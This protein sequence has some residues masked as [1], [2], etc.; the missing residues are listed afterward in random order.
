MHAA[1]D[2]HLYVHGSRATMP[3][4]LAFLRQYLRPRPGGLVEEVGVC[5]RGDQAL[6]ATIVR[7]A[8]M[9]RPLPAWVVLHGLTY[10]GKEHPSLA[11]FTHAVAARASTIVE[12]KSL[13]TARVSHDFP[14]RATTSEIPSRSPVPGASRG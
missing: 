8:R 10:H 9:R 12:M 14:G 13:M 3:S 2:V 7:P 1:A 5:M 6:P 4:T 11:K